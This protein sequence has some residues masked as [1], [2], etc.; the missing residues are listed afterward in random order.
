M[1]LYYSRR[2]D[3]SRGSQPSGYA[4]LDRPD[5]AP[6][7]RGKDYRTL[8]GG[9]QLGLL[10]AVTKSEDADVALAGGQ[11][12][13]REVEPLTNFFVGRTRKTFAGGRG[14]LGAIATSVIRRFEYDSLRLTMPRHSEAVGVD[15]EGW[16]KNRT[17]RLMG[18]MAVSTVVGDPR[19]ILGLQEHS[20]RYFNRPDRSHGD[21]GL[22]P[23]ATIQR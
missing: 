19:A 17:Y 23:T 14:F 12:A 16:W 1:S 13:V 20:A 3:D 5:N 18:N 8:R 11:R 9:Y 22:F 21:N 2:S 4:F 7:S 10:N 6:S 15:G